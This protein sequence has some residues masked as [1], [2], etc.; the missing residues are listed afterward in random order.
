MELG[1]WFRRSKGVP[2][3]AVNTTHLVAAYDELLPER[4][5]KLESV[6]Y[7]V[8]FL[9]KKPF[10][11]LYSSM[12]NKG[13]GLMVLSEGLATYWRERGVSVP[14]HAVPRAVPPNVFDRPLG[15]DPFTQPAHQEGIRF[16]CPGRHVREKA[17]DR[18][19]R[20]FAQHILPQSPSS[21]LNLL[22][23]G[24]DT[25]AFK[26]L[27][28]SLGVADRVFFT[29]EVPY[30]NMVDYYSYAD[31][32]LHAS[33]SET[34]GNVLGEALWCGMP[35]VA[36]ADGMG[37]SSQLQ[38]GING[39]LLNP[40][41]DESA[42][43]A[44]NLAFGTA[45]L[46]LA[47]DPN[48]RARYGHNAARIAR[49][50]AS[51]RTVQNSSWT[52]FWPRSIMLRAA[53]FARLRIAQSFSSGLRRSIAFARGVFSTAACWSQVRCVRRRHASRTQIIRNWARRSCEAPPKSARICS[54]VLLPAKLV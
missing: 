7:G 45:A 3:L 5:A 24:P 46:R 22:G 8:E 47:N 18:I 54:K 38:D 12:Y 17:Q 16:L 28:K 19:I 26:Q 44:A 50:R 53:R 20:I 49:E 14:I 31:I 23:F 40:G 21:T 41:R 25:E 35:A 30:Q 37:T 13:D 27:A 1:V 39:I 32:C 36:F 9:L 42:Q 11:R 6:H 52:P 4:L 51:L 34:Y 15:S 48:L 10:E 33:L 43:S 29:G 2:L